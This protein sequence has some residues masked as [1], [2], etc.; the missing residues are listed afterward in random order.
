MLIV[1]D[2]TYN[3][4]VLEELLSQIACVET[5]MKALNGQEALAIIQEQASANQNICPFDVIL[6]DLHMPIMDGF[7]VSTK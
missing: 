1:D 2:S 6:V 4:F 7:Q 5:V 3:L